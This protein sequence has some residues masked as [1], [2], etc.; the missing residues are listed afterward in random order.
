M[1]P[2]RF[3]GKAVRIFWV[4]DDEWYSGAIDDY[5]P[6]RGWHIQYYDGEEEWLTSLDKNVAFDDPIDDVELSEPEDCSSTHLGDTNLTT[7]SE[8]VIAKEDKSCEQPT[9]L[10]SFQ[11]I[12]S[13]QFSAGRISSTPNSSS[14][15]RASSTVEDRGR[16][17]AAEKEMRVRPKVSTYAADPIRSQDIETKNESVS[18]PSI[19]ES[20]RRRE[21]KE[22]SLHVVEESI[23]MRPNRDSRCDDL[24]R[25]ENVPSRGLLL[26]GTVFGAS[27]LPVADENETDGQ[28]FFR[29]LYVEGTGQSSM[30]RCKTP[31]FAS[32]VT[33]NLQFPQWGEG[34]TFRF[35]MIMPQTDGR[36]GELQL[37]GQILVA[38]Y[39]VRGQGGYEFLGQT[40]FE[41]SELALNGVKDDHQ[42]GIEVRSVSGDYPLIDRF[43]KSIGNYAEVQIN[44]QIAWRPDSFLVDDNGTMNAPKQALMTRSQGDNKSVYSIRGGGSVGGTVRTLQSRGVVS[45][46]A[47][48]APTKSIYKAPPPVKVVSAQQRKQADDKRKIDA[49]NKAMQSR[50]QA[51][52]TRGRGDTV[53]NIYAAQKA[54]PK[55]MSSSSSRRGAKESEVTLEAVLE[56]WTK[57]KKE[58]SEVEDENNLLKATLSKL[59]TQT[60]RHELTTDRLKKQARP[61]LAF[62]PHTDSKNTPIEE[63]EADFSDIADN[64]LREIAMEHSNLQQLRRGLLERIRVA[65]V[66]SDN[67]VSTAST[68]QDAESVLR[69]RIL[70]VAPFVGSNCTSDI[71][72]EQ[73]DLQYVL[74]RLRNVQLDF[75]CAEAAR[76]HGFHFGPLLDAVDEDKELLNLLRKKH[77]D[78]Q[79][80]TENCRRERDEAKYKLEKVI[81][82]KAV[83]KIRDNITELR[84]TLFKL[85]KKNSLDALGTG[86][87]SIEREISRMNLS[88]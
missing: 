64:E 68:A 28:C 79:I 71:T 73:R 35:E 46:P 76:E 82:E 63:D 17:G 58:V 88:P 11:D 62:E 36:N 80:E 51:K 22:E 43:D 26:I 67:H 23:V 61:T 15:A 50:L 48:A 18:A 56:A 77:D 87:N 72:A 85:R 3:V 12:E 45:R 14:S 65:S 47:S 2:G 20:Y 41:L 27:N 86:S 57:M 13:N 39:R 4:D 40:C 37:Q 52:G 6:D 84:D 16:L 42:S 55:P 25:S 78:L 24:I 31:I 69:N 83:Y 75:L 74:N 19:T 32:K 8:L 44:L 10:D 38:V 21:F 1:D 60:K 54:E 30:F 5:H 81:D 70:L 59:K 34:G 29:V 49:Q 33:E 9:V 66:V 53:S 7:F